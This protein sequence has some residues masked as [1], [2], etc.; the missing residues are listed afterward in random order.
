MTLAKYLILRFGR[1]IVCWKFRGDHK[2]SPLPFQRRSP[3]TYS[4]YGR[5]PAESALL[6][7][8][9]QYSGSMKQSSTRTAPKILLKKRD[10]YSRNYS[11]FKRLPNTS[12]E[13]SLLK[14]LSF[15]SLGFYLRCDYR[16][17]QA[18]KSLET[19]S[20]AKG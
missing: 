17:I 20:S 19:A 2:D 15:N 18:L 11:R 9:S 12:G 7:E 4:T 10:D 1:R 6:P 13:Q 5:R 16:V 3:E 8:L 14:T